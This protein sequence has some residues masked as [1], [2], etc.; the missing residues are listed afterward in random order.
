[1]Q[2]QMT[3]FVDEERSGK[4]TRTL[5]SIIPMPFNKG[6]PITVQWLMCNLFMVPEAKADRFVS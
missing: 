3:D 5:C 4:D 1:M 6:E 2:E